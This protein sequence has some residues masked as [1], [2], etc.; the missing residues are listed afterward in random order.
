MFIQNAEQR[1]GQ[2][3]QQKRLYKAEDRTNKY[4]DKKHKTSKRI[5]DF[6]LTAFFGEQRAQK[7][8]VSP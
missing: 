8:K 6:F 4:N 3:E 2:S 1:P 7:Y 5:Y